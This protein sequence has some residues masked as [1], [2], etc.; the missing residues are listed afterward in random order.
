MPFYSDDPVCENEAPRGN[1]ALTVILIV[2]LLLGGFFVKST[3]A[4][5][6]SLNSGN[7]VEFGQGI[8]LAT[9]CSGS[10]KLSVTPS[11]NFVNV[12][13]AGAYYLQGITVSNIPNS[14]YGSDFN[15][16]AYTASGTSPAA[17]FNSSST[18]VL[19]YDNAG[20]FQ[21]G[22]G[23]SGMTITS[24][25][26]AFTATFTTP[27]AVASTINSFTI[28]SS[29]HAPSCAEGG[30]CSLGDSGPGG[31]IIYYVSVS[32]FACGPTLSNNCNYLESAK[33]DWS[34]G[35]DPQRTWAVEPTYSGSLIGANAQGTAIGTGYRNSLA[36]QSQGNGATTGAPTALAY[37]GGGKSDWYLPSS[38]ELDQLYLNRTLVGGFTS[39]D[40]YQ[41]STEANASN[42]YREIFDGSANGFK[43]TNAKRF[44]YY[45]RPIRAF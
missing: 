20:T 43:A 40:G 39:A 28:Q 24:S 10:T 36:I 45:V 44:S 5:N 6:V 17:L 32:T 18:D 1:S 25:T 8:L 22:A 14:C 21:L 35:S 12:S 3:L 30:K 15:L 11:S 7:T 41:T 16:N 4:A 13:G 23:V 27:V 9:S 26:G 19:I 33:G 34:G 38:G 29:P 2:A 42:A 31:G 37:R